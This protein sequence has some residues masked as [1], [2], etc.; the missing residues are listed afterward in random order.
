MGIKLQRVV[1]SVRDV[2]QGPLFLQI[3]RVF[4]ISWLEIAD[5]SSQS[6]QEYTRILLDFNSFCFAQ[7]LKHT[8]L[9]VGMHS[10][11]LK[12]MQKLDE[13]KQSEIRGTSIGIYYALF[14][15]HA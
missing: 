3:F 11:Q 2:A 15:L 9:L 7:Y 8:L 6:I 14:C 12:A 10:N 13:T 1:V 5:T 4:S